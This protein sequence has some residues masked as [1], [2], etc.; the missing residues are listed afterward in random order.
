ME[1]YTFWELGSIE[2]MWE[3]ERAYGHIYDSIISS[4][5]QLPIRGTIKIVQITKFVFLGNDDIGSYFQYL[6]LTAWLH[7]S[8]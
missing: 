3:G 1:S 7:G 8:L 2:F 6:E 5:P 4:Q